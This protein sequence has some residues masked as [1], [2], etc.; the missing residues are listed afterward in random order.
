MEELLDKLATY[1]KKSKNKSIETI[2]KD[3]NLEYY[4]VYGLVMMLKDK[5]YLYDVIDGKVIKLDKPIKES[6]IYQLPCN[7]ETVKLLLISDT[8]LASKYDRLDILR[9]L[10]QKAE[11]RGINYVLHSGD[12]VDGRS[13]RPQH[14]YELKEQPIQS[15]SIPPQNNNYITKEEFEKAIA[16]LRK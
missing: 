9:Y 2:C 12:V 1:L 4:Q 10:Y 14:V 5:G 13:N 11:D 15:P 8:H 16:E 3:L 7:L 6:D